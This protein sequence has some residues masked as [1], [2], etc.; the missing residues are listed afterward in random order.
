M[1]NVEQAEWVVGKLASAPLVTRVRGWGRTNCVLP[2][3]KHP[4]YVG[5][6]CGGVLCASAS[7][8]SPGTLQQGP[9]DTQV[10]NELQVLAIGA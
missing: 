6:P 7:A 9:Q 1:K 4:P 10:I 3:R 8:W 5:N 2:G